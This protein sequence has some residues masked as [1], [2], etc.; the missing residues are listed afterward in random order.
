MHRF[1]AMGQITID[2][3]DV[4]ANFEF[5][6]SAFGLATQMGLST[7]ATMFLTKSSLPEMKP[8]AATLD[9]TAQEPVPKHIRLV[10]YSGHG[11]HQE[12]ERIDESDRAQLPA[13]VSEQLIHGLELH[14]EREWIPL[15][16][17]GSEPEPFSNILLSLRLTSDNIDRLMP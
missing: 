15:V 11:A 5:L 1:P 8:L 6:I 3:S 12:H 10:Y 7:A 17:H 2:G 9:A 14:S 13:F 16:L 4:A